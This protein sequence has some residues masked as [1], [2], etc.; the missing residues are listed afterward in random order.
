MARTITLTDADER[1]LLAD[2]TVADA[3]RHGDSNDDEIEALWS[4]AHSLAELL[5][6]ELD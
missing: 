5:G 1:R 2:L 6:A 4:V 3:A